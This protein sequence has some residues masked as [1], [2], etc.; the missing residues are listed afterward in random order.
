MTIHSHDI[1]WLLNTIPVNNAASH[2]SSP[3][4]RGD[5]TDNKVMTD[6]YCFKGP[7]IFW[8]L[9]NS[10]DVFGFSKVDCYVFL[11]LFL[12]LN[13]CIEKS[14]LWTF[15]VSCLLGICIYIAFNYGRGNYN[16]IFECKPFWFLFHNILVFERYNFTYL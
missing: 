4:P 16:S 13:R 15:G 5:G 3:A 2:S 9:W 6:Y 12:A 11:V 1:T 14:L 7:L 8:L 10:S